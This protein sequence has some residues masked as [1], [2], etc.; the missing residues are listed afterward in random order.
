MAIVET[1]KIQGDG[2]DLQAT[3]DKLNAAAEKLAKSIAAV[4]SQYKDGFDTL[5]NGAKKAGAEINNNLSGSIDKIS[6]SVSGLDNS[7]FNSI[8]KGASE[9][10]L[11]INNNLSGSID[12]VSENIG[13]MRTD[14][15]KGF[16]AIANDVSK[17]SESVAADLGNLSSSVTSDVNKISSAISD[18]DYSG[19]NSIVTGANEAASEINNNLNGSIENLSENIDEVFTD[20]KKGFNA[21]ATDATK[22]SEAI[23]GIKIEPLKPKIET[24]EAKEDVEELSDYIKKLITL[25]SGVQAQSKTS[26]EKTETAIKEVQKETK[27]ANNT[28]KETK[29]SIEGVR[30]ETEKAASSF[31]DL[32]SSAKSF[33]LV[34]L[35]LDTAKDAFTANQAVADVFNTALGAVQLS[36]SRIFDSITKGTPL[37]L[38]TVISDSQE[39]VKLENQAALAAAKRTEVQLS[40]QLLAEQARQER[41]NEFNSIE[42]RIEANDIL[43]DILTEQLEKEKALVEQVVAATQA[44]YEKIPSIEN[45]VALIQA[46]TELVDIE[47]RVAGQRSEFLMNQMSLNREMVTY[48]ELIQKNGDVIYDEYV[49]ISGIEEN[50]RKALDLE[51]NKQVEILDIEIEIAH[52]RLKS[53]AEGT[54]AQ[55]EAYDAYLQLLQDK[56]AAES[57]YARDSKELDR[58]VTAAKFQMAKDGIAA[59][60]ALSAAFANEDEESKRR[61][62]EFQKKLSLATAVISGIEAVQNAYTT[63]QKSPYTAAFPGYPYVQAGLAAAFSVAQVASIARTQY[64]SPDTNFDTGGAG[65]P[66]QPQLTPQ[67]NVVGRSGINQLAQSVNERNQQ[68]IQAYVVAGEVTNAQQLARRART[69]TFG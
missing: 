40:Y 49:I 57:Q 12:K 51:Y 15:N 2:S 7:G 65:A 43:N 45:E 16:G 62:F 25:L 66:S 53:A 28:F 47:E 44:Q 11:E 21:I 23:G 9:A 52:Q 64:D 42:S 6:D 60:S 3:I 48:N 27:K 55:Q 30:Q 29:T 4:Q 67:F 59:I 24:E 61:Q 19:F 22:A 20:S 38:G 14:S 36:V 56:S 10:A 8:S 13:A 5:A 41:D 34:S 31:K 33:A 54:V 32:A 39:I 1:V 68:P 46:R 50:R 69:A 26:F 58:E 35:A 37:N 17:V 18:L 63:A